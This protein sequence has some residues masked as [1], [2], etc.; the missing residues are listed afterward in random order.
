MALFPIYLVSSDAVFTGN[1]CCYCR[2]GYWDEFGDRK[3]EEKEGFCES[4]EDRISGNQ[5]HSR[6]PAAELGMRLK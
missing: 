5:D 1:A 3:L 2:L 6:F 4:L